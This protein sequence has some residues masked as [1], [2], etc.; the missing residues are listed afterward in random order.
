MTTEV[1]GLGYQLWGG[2]SGGTVLRNPM[3]LG[4]YFL[5]IKMGGVCSVINSPAFRRYSMLPT[6]ASFPKPFIFPL[7]VL[8]GTTSPCR[9]CSW[10][11]LCA[12]FSG[13][14]RTPVFALHFFQRPVPCLCPVCFS[15]WNPVGALLILFVTWNNFSQQ[16]LKA[17]GW[18]ALKPQGSPGSS[19]GLLLL[20]MLTYR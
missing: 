20:S 9:L 8:I 17:W 6:M 7:S 12:C 16:S 4:F 1:P 2:E 10:Y 18:P 15:H 5:E 14:H 11:A 3:L 19:F 13:Q